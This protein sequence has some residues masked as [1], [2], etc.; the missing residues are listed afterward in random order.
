MHAQR[1]AWMTRRVVRRAFCV[2]VMIPTDPWRNSYRF[3][4]CYNSTE[5]IQP[6][7]GSVN[8][9]Q[10]IAYNLT[11]T[12]NFDLEWRSKLAFVTTIKGAPYRLWYA[13]ILILS[14]RHWHFPNQTSQSK[15]FAILIWRLVLSRCWQF[16][17]HLAEPVVMPPARMSSYIYDTGLRRDL[18]WRGN[19]PLVAAVS[20]SRLQ[21]V[22]L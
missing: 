5:E 11:R 2:S 14:S 17:T 19:A 13:F 4:S 1:S 7:L 15:N 22:S 16:A 8:L 9:S 21:L 6:P 18:A 3:F 12:M 10:I 20:W